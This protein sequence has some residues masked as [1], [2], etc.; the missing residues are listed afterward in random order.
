MVALLL[1][2]ALGG[3][4][5]EFAAD[6]AFFRG[7]EEL[8]YAEIYYKIPYGELTYEGEEELTA[9][10]EFSFC[11][12]NLATGDSVVDRW[13]R[14]SVIPS[15]EE[16]KDRDLEIVE[17]AKLLLR[18]GDYRFEYGVADVNSSR[19]VLLVD[20]VTVPVLWDDEMVL[21]SI[22]LATKIE[23]DSV[24]GQ[25]F[26]NGLRVIPNPGG[27]YSITRSILYSY[28]E[29][30]NLSDDTLLVEIGYSIVDD[31]GE[32]VQT[33]PAKHLS[34]TGRDIVDV[35]VVNV[36]G[37]PTGD[38]RFRVTVADSGS[39][40]TAYTEREIS[41]VP[42]RSPP[43]PGLEE[44]Y[45]MLEYLVT[46]KELEF[47]ESLSDKAKEEYLYQFWRKVDPNP[48]SKENEALVLFAERIRYADD[49]YSIPQKSGRHTDRGRIYIKYGEPDEIARSGVQTL[50][51]SWESW[52]YYG[53]GGRQFIFVDLRNTGTY[54]LVYS[55]IP[56]EPTRPDW[57]E[58][59]DPSAVEFKR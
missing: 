59:V 32:A 25:F 4:Q 34:K 38:Y 27:E 2:L 16:A 3:Q 8:T 18:P 51:K 26:K 37:V 29:I 39:G 45:S 41:V 12:N 47:Y 14:R 56:E 42:F 48:A 24:P 21:S 49:R 15:F 28:T 58:W 9:T 33:F 46:P 20:T 55:S 44:Y 13:E 40:E 19:E 52:L 36:V 6:H 22:E 53:G 35:G 54:D 5:M 7:V 31:A 10:I 1:L 23:E 57:E 11:V 50:F 43:P 17:V 30:Y